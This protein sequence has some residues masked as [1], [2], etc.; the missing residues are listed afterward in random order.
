M[1]LAE[2]AG[3]RCAERW[4]LREARQEEPCLRWLRQAGVSV[5]VVKVSR[6]NPSCP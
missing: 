1:D 6:D 4:P 2:A 5:L 3:S